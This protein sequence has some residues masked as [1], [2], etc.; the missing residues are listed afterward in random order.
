ML[1]FRLNMWAGLRRALFKNATMLIYLPEVP[2]ILAHTCC[3]VHCDV[4]CADKG[5]N[6]FLKVD[7]GS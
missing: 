5:V 1:T 3:P 6:V 2:A 4:Q 7:L